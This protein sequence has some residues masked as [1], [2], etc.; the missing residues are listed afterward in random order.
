VQMLDDES[1]AFE[2]F[3]CFLGCPD[4][5][6]D[7]ARTLF[8]DPRSFD[9]SYPELQGLVFRRRIDDLLMP[10]TPAA[11]ALAQSFDPADDPAISCRPYGLVRQALSPLPIEFTQSGEAVT[12]RY[13]LWGAER[14]ISLDP[15]SDRS[16]ERS[17]FGRAVG[18]YEGQTLVVETTEI[19]ADVVAADAHVLHSDALRT[20][21]RY[22]LSDDGD[23]LDLELSLIDP[24]TFTA[25]LTIRTA[26]R[27][28]PMMQLLPYQCRLIGTRD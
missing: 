10:L 2:D 5:T 13:E 24:E 19:S 16:E 26:W 3:A 1:W 6:F 28:A 22:T 11:Q 14:V 9:R 12:I 25:P 20:T 27:R 7:Y 21:E 23:R 17:P 4:A 18:H 15:R 8:S